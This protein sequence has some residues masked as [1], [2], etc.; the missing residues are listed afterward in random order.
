MFNEN[1]KYAR[2]KYNMTPNDYDIYFDYTNIPSN[3]NLESASN[4]Y[5]QLQELMP[6]TQVIH[7]HFGTHKKEPVNNIQITTSM[8]L[9]TKKENIP[10]EFI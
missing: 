3:I 7:L 8:T 2:G 9:R 10:V 6:L 5:L 1:C 4:L